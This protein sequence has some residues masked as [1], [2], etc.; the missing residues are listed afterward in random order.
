M[1]SLVLFPPNSNCFVL[2]ELQS[3]SSHLTV[4]Q[5]ET[6]FGSFVPEL[7]PEKMSSHCNSGC[8]AVRLQGSPCLILFSQGSQPCST[9]FQFAKIIISCNFVR[10][11]KYA[12]KSML[13]FLWAACLQQASLTSLHCDQFP[14]ATSKR[15]QSLTHKHVSS[16][17]GHF[18]YIPLA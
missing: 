2:F 1:Y 13:T 3:L 17:S 5:D 7:Q 11:Y 16:L 18:C 8:K 10:F 15:G 12:W 6:C 9:F 4:T 14:K